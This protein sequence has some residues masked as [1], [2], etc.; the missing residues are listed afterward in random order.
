MRLNVLLDSGSMR[1]VISLDYFQCMRLGD[2]KLQLLET[3]LTCV[4]ASGQS[5][6]IVVEVKVPLK[7]HGFS[8]TWMF[9]VSRR[10]SSQP[11]LGPILILKIRLYWNWAGR[12]AF[13][14]LLHRSL[15]GSVRVIIR[16]VRKPA[17]FPHASPSTNGKI[18]VR[19]KSPT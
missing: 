9:L 5:L 6:E 12:S 7:I 10:L 13:L 15:S 19:A 14:R 3:Q 18:F 8:W 11:I 17:P 4:T 2:P 1:S 16:R